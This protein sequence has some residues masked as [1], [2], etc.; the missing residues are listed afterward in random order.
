LRELFM[1]NSMAVLICG[2]MLNGRM[3]IWALT[4][5][6]H[7]RLYFSL[8]YNRLRYILGYLDLN[9]GC[10]SPGILYWLGWLKNPSKIQAGCKSSWHMR[11]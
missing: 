2:R 10:K 5:W 1:L 7:F 3:F 8:A 4:Y 11:I 9:N 6:T